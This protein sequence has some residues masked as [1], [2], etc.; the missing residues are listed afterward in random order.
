[1]GWAFQQGGKKTVTT[2]GTR[3]QLTTSDAHKNLHGIIIAPDP[4]N[5]GRVFV[6]DEDVAADAHAFSLGATQDPVII[7]SEHVIGNLD[8]TTIYV[9]AANNNDAVQWGFW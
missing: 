9:D 3:V 2:A 6:G 5:V 7:R 4:D 1:M 8:A